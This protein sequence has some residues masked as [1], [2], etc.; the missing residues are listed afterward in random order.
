MENT[1]VSRTRPLPTEQMSEIQ[2]RRA[3][4]LCLLCGVARATNQNA[5]QPEQTC[6]QCERNYMRRINQ[7]L[8][9][10]WKVAA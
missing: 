3:A 8:A 4:G 9:K 1:Q 5:V 2:F 6:D 10:I 7:Y